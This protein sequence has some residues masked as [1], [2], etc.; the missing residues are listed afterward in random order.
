MV[1]QMRACPYYGMLLSNKKEWISDTIW[2]KLK[3]IM[4]SFQVKKKTYCM[5][6][7]I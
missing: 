6:P 7:L 2:M 3:I 1:K 5:I 4:L